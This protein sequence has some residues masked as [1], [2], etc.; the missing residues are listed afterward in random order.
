[1]YDE[2]TPY[3]VLFEDNVLKTDPIYYQSFWI[4]REKSIR[5]IQKEM[6]IDDKKMITCHGFQIFSK[7]VLSDFKKKFMD[8]NGYTYS[9]LMEISPYE[10]SWYNF[11]LQKAKPI[12]IHFCDEI[13]HCYH[14]VHQ[15]VYAV[16]SGIT[17]KDLERS[18][19]GLV[20]NSNFQDSKTD[21]SFDDIYTY[22]SMLPFS[23]LMIMQKYIVFSCIRR[24]FN[25][26]SLFFRKVKI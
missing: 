26:I 13:F 15:H 1:M 16:L 2:D 24:F 3:S 4:E 5:K 20:L 9:S 10:F 6:A 12:A 19:V 8:I 23:R 18:Y 11:W 7:K 22:D 14:M 25:K 21:R 17:I